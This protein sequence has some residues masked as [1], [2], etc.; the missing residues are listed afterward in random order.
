MNLTESQLFTIEALNRIEGFAWPE[1]ANHAFMNENDRFVS[2][3]GGRRPSVVVAIDRCLYAGVYAG[4]VSAGCK[5]PDWRNSLITREQF[6]SVDGWVRNTKMRLPNKTLYSQ[7]EVLYDNSAMAFDDAISVYWDENVDT[8]R[9][10][11][12]QKQEATTE[13]QPKSLDQ[14]F[15][16]R[17]KMMAD[18]SVTRSNLSIINY[19]IKA[20]L[21]AQGWTK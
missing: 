7:I 2:F 6:E 16:E 15:A 5:H 11:K 1:N 20:L 8:W 9:Y 4:S 19:E 14:L 13:K 18:L 17:K 12:P 3:T 10:R 21:T